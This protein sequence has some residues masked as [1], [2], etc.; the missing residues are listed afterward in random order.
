MEQLDKLT[1]L[2]NMARG[3]EG[4]YIFNYTEEMHH[5]FENISGSH[6][7]IHTNHEFATEHGFDGRVGYGF[8]VSAML[9]AMV[10][11][12]IPRKFGL[13]GMCQSVNVDFRKPVYLNDVLTYSGKISGVHKS[14]SLVVIDVIVTNQDNV[15]VMTA[16]MKAK[17]FE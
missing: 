11:E 1:K 4:E 17:V 7:P 9:S 10:G 14:I 8:L 6:N 13:Y 12:H 15:I 3:G 5:L 2:A 16:Q